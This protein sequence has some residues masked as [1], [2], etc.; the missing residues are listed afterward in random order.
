MARSAVNALLAREF[1]PA[2]L[3]KMIYSMLKPLLFRLD[4]ETAHDRVSRRM[5]GFVRLPGGP[6]LL[7][8]LFA[9]A[10][11]RLEQRGLGLHFPNPVGMAA[12][13]DKSGD[14]YPFLAH[15]GFGF[16]ESGTFTAHS[17]PGNPRPRLFRFPEAGA[18]VNRMGFNNAGSE[19]VADLIAHQARPVIRG[20]NLGKSKITPVEAAIDDYLE[21]LSRLQPHAD[22]IAIN[23][24]SPNTPGLRSLQEAGKM[25]SLLVA[26]RK[27]MRPGLPLF[28]KLAP[29]L[30]DRDLDATLDAVRE[31]HTDGL[32]LTN[33]TLDKSS[34]PEASGMEGGLSGRPLADRSTAIIRRAYRRTEGKLPIIGVGGIFSG[35]DA[36]QKIRAGASLVQIYT[37]YIYEGP[38][39]PARICRFL[40]AY[41]ESRNMTL[42]A[43]TGS[44][45]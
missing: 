43:L 3:A 20:I 5:S 7:R 4:P 23:V 28:V 12:G 8:S 42:P 13:F 1:H 21:S 39:L 33:T 41:L 36:L 40:A 18:L 38:M 26:V 31:A 25:R 16:V 35:E 45:A 19:V 29:D 10:S 34:V 14:L 24:S 6:A 44:D 9:Y 27:A 15:M 11:P 17:Q 30:T 22:Y 32:I 2:K 37:G